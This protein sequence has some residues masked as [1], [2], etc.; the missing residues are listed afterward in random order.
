MQPPWHRTV[1]D[2]R[3]SCHTTYGNGVLPNRIPAPIP[4]RSLRHDPR[5]DLTAVFISGWEQKKGGALETSFV[6]QLSATHTHT[7][8]P[9]PPSQKKSQNKD[10]PNTTVSPGRAQ[11][12]R[13]MLSAWRSKLRCR[14]GWAAGEANLVA[15]MNTLGFRVLGASVRRGCAV[16][17]HQPRR[18]TRQR[19]PQG[20]SLN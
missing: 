11:T 15:R 6:S 1:T 4:Y 5:F 3:D 8:I 9:N 7:Y 17:H 16:A 2:K 14:C 19:Y 18:A 13:L 12:R 20:S 10:I